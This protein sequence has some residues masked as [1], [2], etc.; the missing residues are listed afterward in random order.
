MAL[1]GRD[2]LL[3][4]L[5]ADLVAHR[6]VLLT[7]A[8]GSGRTAVLEALAP[9]GQRCTRISGRERHH[10]VPFGPWSVLLSDYQARLDKPLTVYTELPKRVAADLDLVLVDDLDLFDP[11]S[12]MLTVQLARAGLRF[13]ATISDP[14]AVPD[15]LRDT[16]RRWQRRDLDPLSDRDIEAVAALALEAPLAAPT[17]AKMVSWSTGL[18][19]VTVALA[20][21]A[22]RGGR[23]VSTAGGARIDDPLVP[24]DILGY[25][26]IDVAAARA[27][28]ERVELVAAAGTL[29]RA[30]LDEQDVLRLTRLGLVRCVD[31]EVRPAASLLAAWALRDVRADH[32]REL[33]THAAGLI[34]DLDPE[35]RR[36]RILDVCAGSAATLDER[37]DAAHWLT[38]EG[39]PAEAVT[40]LTNAVPS[41]SDTTAARWRWC[42][43]RAQLHR[44]LGELPAAVDAWDDAVEYA[45]NDAQ[46]VQL[47]TGWASVLGGLLDED[48]RLEERINRILPLLGDD[49][50]RASVRAI[51]GRRRVILGERGARGADTSRDPIVLL[52]REAM[53]G[54]LEFAREHFIPPSEDA[55]TDDQDLDELLQ[56]LGRFL[57]LVF[58]GQ[59]V[60]GRAEAEERH[61]HAL[62]AA[63]PSLGLWSYNRT[64]IAFHAGQYGLAVVR[65]REMRRHLAWRDVAVQRLPG[66]ALLAAAL[67]R[68]GQLAEAAEIVAELGEAERALPRVLIG[69]RR[70]QAEELLVSGDASGAAALLHDAGRYALEAGE[71]HAGLLTI[72]EAFMIDPTPAYAASL[73][74]FAGQSRIAAAAADRA[75]ARLARDPAG[76]EVAA[77]R[78]AEMPLPGRAAQAWEWAAEIY[79]HDG[80]DELAAALCASGRAA[81]LPVL[82]CPLA[83]RLHT[84]AHRSRAR[85]R[86]PGGRAQ[87]EPG[88]R[89]P[90]RPVGADGGQPPGQDL[91][92]ARRRGPRR[93]RRRAVTGAVD[94]P[95][96]SVA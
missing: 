91:P 10:G 47:V 77:A 13:V 1:V 9:T 34:A 89:R 62:E 88:D 80:R 22:Q 29:P 52:L 2:A 94:R 16:V 83:R 3:R 75:D 63:H 49:D 48:D 60:E 50:A 78:F 95:V 68:D 46:L 70:V 92:Q 90:A 32:L 67:A 21:S 8:R 6:P 30:A 58:N 27:D 61:Q 38:A 12:A 54:S 5:D 11:A 43:L 4:A 85:D 40:L 19:A 66:E 73:R 55:V 57:G 51:L 81:G 39:R 96:A 87:P 84:P 36:P 37:V 65:G 64:K 31:D 14:D 45:E 33:Y 18:P 93:A 26:G 41:R 42:L 7:G 76:L 69:V 79:A 28:R 25:L 53:G 15:A 20:D 82:A 17:A 59:L 44:E 71:G 56:V 72:D 24:D 86:A 23:V 35:R 74:E